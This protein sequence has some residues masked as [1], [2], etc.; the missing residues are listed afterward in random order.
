[1]QFNNLEIAD[2]RNKNLTMLHKSDKDIDIVESI[3]NARQK[4]KAQ[5][6]LRRVKLAPLNATIQPKTVEKERLILAINDS[7]AETQLS[8]EHE[9]GLHTTMNLQAVKVNPYTAEGIKGRRRT[10]KP[11]EQAMNTYNTG[12][13]SF[14]I[15]IK[16]EGFTS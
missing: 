2:L 12:K 3:S 16:D 9:R 15:N 1:M 5:E 14:K 4:M 7:E 6:A 8:Y 11:L 10:L 13:R